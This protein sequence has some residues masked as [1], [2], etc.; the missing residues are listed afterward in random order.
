MKVYKE[1]ILKELRNKSS[2]E[3]KLI[4]GDSTVSED[5]LLQILEEAENYYK[6]ENKRKINEGYLKHGTKHGKPSIPREKQ[7]Q[8]IELIKAG[9][10]KEQIARKL[11]ICSKTV[12]KYCRVKDNEQRGDQNEEDSNK[13]M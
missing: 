12:R 13:D 5:S 11:G 4:I 7:E 3:D 9:L 1:Q 2:S 8:I 6:T 10:S